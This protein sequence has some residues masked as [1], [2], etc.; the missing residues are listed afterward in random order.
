MSSINSSVGCAA[1]TFCMAFCRDY[2]NAYSD[3]ELLTN[4]WEFNASCHSFKSDTPPSASK[5]CRAWFKLPQPRILNQRVRNR[6][7]HIPLRSTPPFSQRHEYEIDSFTYYQLTPNKR[8]D[9]AVVN[10]SLFAMRHAFY[11]YDDR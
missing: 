6:Q 10:P 9:L 11:F 8:Q 7:L 4:N 1:H 2:L 3:L 5:R